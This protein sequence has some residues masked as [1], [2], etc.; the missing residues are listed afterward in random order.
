MGES[1]SFF[2]EKADTRL[3]K[4]QIRIIDEAIKAKPDKYKNRSTFIRIGVQREIQNFKLMHPQSVQDVIEK[5]E[6][7]KI[8]GKIEDT[9]P[10]DIKYQIE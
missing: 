10:D 7:E 8:H 2:T 6:Y 1:L 9:T 4:D 3:T 5:K